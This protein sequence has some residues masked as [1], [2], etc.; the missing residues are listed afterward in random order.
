MGVGCTVVVRVGFRFGEWE[1]KQEG[2]RE[3]ER[4]RGE[5]KIGNSGKEEGKKG[6]GKRREEKK[7]D[8]ERET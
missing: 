1:R 4:D 2:E 3:K 6:I 5:K 7:I 8:G